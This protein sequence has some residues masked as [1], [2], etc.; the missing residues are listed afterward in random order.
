MEVFDA[1][2]ARVQRRISDS[3]ELV[4]QLADVNNVVPSGH[5]DIQHITFFSIGISD[6]NIK[7]R[8]HIR[9]VAIV[10]FATKKF[11]RSINRILENELVIKGP[12]K[13]L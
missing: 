6:D 5:F 9:L 4:T 10:T 11:S 12:S 1:T 2:K 3:I 7:D 13:N 8:S